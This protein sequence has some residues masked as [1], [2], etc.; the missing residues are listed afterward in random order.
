M[1]NGLA[2]SYIPKEIR[3][4]YIIMIAFWA[5][6]I[7]GN[8]LYL[9]TSPMLDVI[10]VTI[11]SLFCIYIAVIGASFFDMY[12]ARS[13]SLPHYIFAIVLWIGMSYAIYWTVNKLEFSTTTPCAFHIWLG[14]VIYFFRVITTEFCFI[15]A[16]GLQAGRER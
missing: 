10:T 8:I 9:S 14:V 6:Y 16:Q 15:L 11:G 3:E 1:R 5:S 2:E 12:A 4:V 7:L 13:G